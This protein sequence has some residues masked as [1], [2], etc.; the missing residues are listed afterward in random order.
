MMKADVHVV[1]NTPGTKSRAHKS[2]SITVTMT[3]LMAD[4]MTGG[5]LKG[6]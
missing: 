5:H 3:S 1:T 6:V 2:P 4:F